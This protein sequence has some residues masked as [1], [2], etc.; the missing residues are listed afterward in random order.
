MFTTN[1]RNKKESSFSMNITQFD[2]HNTMKYEIKQN[3]HYNCIH[4]EQDTQQ[5]REMAK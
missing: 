2:H 3:L 1:S 5:E 4:P